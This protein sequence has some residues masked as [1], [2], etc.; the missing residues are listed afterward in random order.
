MK[1]T[2]VF[3]VGVGELWFDNF[4]PVLIF[5]AVAVMFAGDF[6]ASF[7]VGMALVVKIDGADGEMNAFGFNNTSDEG[8][9]IIFV[10]FFGIKIGLVFGR[11]KTVVDIGDPISTIWH[12][13]AL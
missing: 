11:I 8:E 5:A 7:L 1:K 12:T 10:D 9:V 3:D 13:G 4:R 2:D 6:E